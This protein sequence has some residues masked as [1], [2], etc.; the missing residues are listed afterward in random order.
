MRLLLIGHTG[1]LGWELHRALLPLG[2]V[3]VCDQP[4]VDLSVPASLPALLDQARPDIIV[5]AAAYTAVDAAETQPELAY[6][7]NA[8][9]PGVL[10]DW[11][12][13]HDAALIHYSTDYVF[14]GTLG[15]PY[16]E[17]DTP[18]PCNV[19]GASKLAGEAAIVAADPAHLILRTSWVYSLRRPSFVTSVLRWSQ[20]QDTLRI[21]SDQI[22]SPTWARQL[23]EIT[24]LLLARATVDPHAWIGA[25]R[26][27]YHLAG[28]GAASRLDWAA[29]IIADLPHPP[30]LEAARTADFPS[31]AQRP[32][33]SALDCARFAST[34]G[35]RLPPWQTALQLALAAL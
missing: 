15:R 27:I 31:P 11:A 17:A 21:V 28:D 1:Q 30:H 26:G 23:A 20:T 13:A 9:S 14:D 16:H 32:S 24:A 18:A 8:H 35:L 10:A 19:Y 33:F 29:A 2:E 12:A 7:V 4:Q 34:F 3:Q 25:R 5:N 22:G 6:A